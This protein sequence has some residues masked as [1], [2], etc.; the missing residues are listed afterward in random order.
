MNRHDIAIVSNLEIEEIEKGMNIFETDDVPTKVIEFVILS[1]K[2][3]SLF[4]SVSEIH[5]SE[6]KVYYIYL[7]SGSIIKFHN[8][9]G[10]EENIEFIEYFINEQQ[11]K[12]M[13][14]LIDG[15]NPIYSSL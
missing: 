13:V 6:N 4:S 1:L 14:E 10:F 5:Y 12:V 15:I 8:K 3:N 7:K 2:D 11:D 9:T